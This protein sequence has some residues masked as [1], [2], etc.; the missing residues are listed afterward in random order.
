M[1]RTLVLIKSD[2]VQRALTG[3]ILQRFEDAGLKIIGLKMA[4]VDT[5]FAAKH[6]FDLEER[7]GEKVFKLTA[8]YLTEGPVVAMVLE[9]VDTC[10]N[11]RRITGETQPS[12]SAPG[13]IRGDFAH[14]GYA[15]AD[16][17]GRAIRN[18]IHASGNADE[19]SIEIPLWFTADELHD[20]STDAQK[21]TF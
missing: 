11:V 12:A 7:K 1:E 20:Y 13:T 6:Y 19:A 14:H 10:A 16:K 5:D 2:G 8:D 15:H 4:W 9:G 3:R 17:T 21:H 18:L